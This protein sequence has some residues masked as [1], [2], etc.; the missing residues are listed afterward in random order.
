MFSCTGVSAG[1]ETLSTRVLIT[2][3]FPTV[4][5]YTFMD[6]ERKDA[7]NIVVKAEA[8]KQIAGGF[9][10]REDIRDNMRVSLRLFADKYVSSFDCHCVYSFE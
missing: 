2:H 8:F 10:S 5:W 1:K 7:N 6:S 4:H 9:F 3:T